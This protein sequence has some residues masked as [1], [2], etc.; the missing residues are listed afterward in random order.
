LPFSAHFRLHVKREWLLLSSGLW[1]S[2]VIGLAF[3]LIH[4]FMRNAVYM[5]HEPR[6][7]LKDLGF[8]LLPT[9]GQWAKTVSEFITFGV[10]ISA[11]VYGLSPFVIQ[12]QPTIFAVHAF[13]RFFDT[14]T[15][16][17]VL[18]IMSF[19]VTI[20]PA[21]NSHCQPGSPEYHP[22]TSI[23]EVFTNFD[24]LHV[25]VHPWF[26]RETAE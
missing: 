7:H 4:N 21:P 3:Q 19:M 23:G 15:I 25:H 9:F 1:R 24:V 20:L 6:P 5:L 22:P 17:G 14:V 13:A 16:C 10:L 18:R 26:D 8:L 2:L 11:L 12:R